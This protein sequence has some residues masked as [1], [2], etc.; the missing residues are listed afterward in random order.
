VQTDPSPGKLC[1]G[2]ALVKDIRDQPQDLHKGPHAGKAVQVM[3]AP[4]AEDPLTKGPPLQQQPPVTPVGKELRGQAWDGVRGALPG[5]A[6]GRLLV[7]VQVLAEWDHHPGVKPLL[8]HAQVLQVAG[9]P[10]HVA[11]HVGAG[12]ARPVLGERLQ[13]LPALDPAR[14]APWQHQQQHV[15]QGAKIEALPA[16]PHVP[17]EGTNLPFEGRVE[18]LHGWPR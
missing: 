15:V 12:R 9:Q 6:G 2:Q 7:H 10:A 16:P 13:V 4:G 1:R 5:R 17:H 14:G 18:G 8:Q 11:G 3:Q